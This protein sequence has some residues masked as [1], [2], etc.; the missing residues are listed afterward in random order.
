[1][2]DD[3]REAGAAVEEP[4][5]VQFDALLGP[6]RDVQGDPALGA[7]QQ[8]RA[9]ADDPFPVNPL[10][11]FPHESEQ[12][13]REVRPSQDRGLA[14]LDDQGPDLS[15]PLRQVEVVA[16]GLPAALLEDAV[17]LLDERGC[18]PRIV[19]VH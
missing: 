13:L 19:D 3:L 12:P 9:V 18:N 16:P 1:M 10:H 15:Q 4:V 17:E 11:K 2:L 14:R 8:L 6:I 5:D 7:V